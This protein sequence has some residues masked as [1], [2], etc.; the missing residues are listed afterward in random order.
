MIESAVN[1]RVEF[2]GLTFKNPFLL[3]SGSPTL[4][5]E[6]I[7]R[8]FEHGWAGAV[9]KTLKPPS[10]RRNWLSRE[11][12]PMVAPF[13]YKGRNIGMQNIATSGGH[14]EMADWQAQIPPIKAQYPEHIV[15][16]SIA[17]TKD[18]GDWKWL[19]EGM[20]EAGVDAIELDVSCS[21][22]SAQLV[23]GRLVGEVTELAGK[24]TRWVREVCDRPVIVKLPAFVPDFRSM[25]EVCAEAGAAG[26]SG[27][28]TLPCLI[29]VNLET[30]EPLLSVQGR[31]VYGGLSGPV[32]KPVALRAVSLMAKAGVLP[33]SGI[34]GI[35]SW[36]DAAEFILLGATTVQLCTAVMW[37]GYGIIE[38]LIGGLSQYVEEKGLW[39]VSELV[40]CSN[41]LI[42]PSIANLQAR[43]GIFAHIIP[44]RCRKC[45]LCVVAC[46]DGGFQAIFR[47]E[48]E[49]AVVDPGRCD[50]CGLCFVVCPADAI[51]WRQG[52]T[53][54]G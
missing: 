44:E 50:G 26:V 23:K 20:L 42:E 24:V 52:G 12:Q 29:G 41:V 39:S 43:S 7:A 21:H 16:G 28:N 54:E 17:A 9:T 47:D 6:M 8:A 37:H 34:G 36:E 35:L 53:T 33:V 11:P 25:V 32:I 31:G 10:L 46:R 51:E 14:M 18:E 45:G 1:L 15:I 30:F 22:S 4:T 2:A 40:G 3:A 38:E 27:I 49:T 48:K 5:G 19:T 13:K